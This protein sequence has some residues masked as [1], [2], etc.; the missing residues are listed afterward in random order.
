[1]GAYGG[2]TCPMLKEYK[3]CNTF[4]C[5]IDCKVTGWTSFTAC[6]ATCG[7][8]TK[9]RTR[10]IINMHLHGG[11]TCPITKFM[12]TCQTFHC[13]VDCRLSSWTAFTACTATCGSGSKKRSRSITTTNLHGGVTCPMLKEYKTCNSFACPIDCVH[14]WNP[15][16]ACSKSCGAGQQSRNYAVDVS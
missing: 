10:S 12:K 16:K 13:P 1:M 9:F 15:W 7:S 4:A 6:S 3:T 5:P 8:G 11:I 2:V 14:S